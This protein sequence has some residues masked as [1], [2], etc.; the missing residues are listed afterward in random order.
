MS[1][2]NLLKMSEI[3]KFS[4][5][6]SSFRI[7]FRDDLWNFS[8]YLPLNLINPMKQCVPI[9]L[10]PRKMLGWNYTT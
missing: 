1:T 5:H 2:C 3:I 8:R 7:N 4:C 6:I 10:D 9:E